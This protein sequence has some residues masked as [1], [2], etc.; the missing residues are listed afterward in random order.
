VSNPDPLCSALNREWSRRTGGRFSIS[1]DIAVRFR[2]LGGGETF[3]DPLKGV[4]TVPCK[5]RVPR[6][7]PDSHRRLGQRPFIAGLLLNL[8]R[9]VALFVAAALVFDAG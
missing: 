3:R 1:Y 4:G 7:P 9:I 8:T 2:T 5:P 6:A